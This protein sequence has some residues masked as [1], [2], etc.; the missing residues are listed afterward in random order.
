MARSPL[1][2]TVLLVGA[3]LTSAAVASEKSRR[4][5]AADF[6]ARAS[7]AVVDDMT[8]SVTR[9]HARPDCFVSYTPVEVTRGIRH[10]TGKCH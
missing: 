9:R 6:Y 7:D 1:F 4:T 8:S 2:L 3:S 10:W 5:R